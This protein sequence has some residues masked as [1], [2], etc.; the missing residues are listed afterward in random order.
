MEIIC[1]ILIIAGAIGMILFIYASLKIS[2][3]IDEEENGNNKEN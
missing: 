3:L 2:E 1:L